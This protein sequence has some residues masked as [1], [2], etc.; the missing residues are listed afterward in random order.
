MKF[1]DPILPR[2]EKWRPPKWNQVNCF[3]PAN[4]VSPCEK[5]NFVASQVPKVKCFFHNPLKWSHL[6]EF[7]FMSSGVTLITFFS[8]PMVG[9]FIPMG[10]NWSEFFSPPMGG[11]SSHFSFLPPTR[12]HLKW[13]FFHSNGGLFQKIF[14]SQGFYFFTFLVHRFWLFPLSSC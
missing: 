14:H 5:E 13:L 11:T 4:G 10:I 1:K 12:G 2:K 3:S 7:F 6:S 8:V 9:H